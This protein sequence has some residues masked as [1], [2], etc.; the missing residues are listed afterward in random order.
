VLFLAAAAQTCP[1]NIGFENGLFTGWQCFAG[2][3][4]P[5][6]N[7]FLMASTPPVS[8]RHNIIENSATP[9]LD[10]YG[11]F[12]VT[13]PNSSNFSVK[14]GNDSAG[15]EAEGIRYTFTIPANRNDYS[16]IYYYALV[17]Q[18]PDHLPHEQPR[19]TSRVYN[20]TDG[21]YIDCASFEYVSTLGLPGFEESTVMHDVYFKPWAPISINLSGYAGKQIRLEF[22]S[23]DCTIGGHFGYAYIDVN[24]N[25]HAPVTGNYVC[26][27]ADSII[28]KAPPGFNSY[29]WY[30][31]DFTLIG[32]GPA[33]TLKPVPPPGTQFMLEIIPYNGLGCY[34]TLSTVISNPT[35]PINLVVTDSLTACEDKGVNLTLPAVTAGSS[36]GLFLEYFTGVN[37][38]SHVP[39]PRKVIAGGTYYI[40]ATNIEGCQAMQPVEVVLQ[41][42]PLMAITDP[43]PIT[44]PDVVDITDAFITNGSLAGLIFTYWRDEQATSPLSNPQ[45][46][47]QGGTYFIKGTSD[48]GCSNIKPVKVVVL[49][50]A[51]PEVKIPNAFSPNNDGVND[52]FRIEVGGGYNVSRFTVY[53]RWGG[54]VFSA[55]NSQWDGRANGKDLPLGTYYWV[56]ESIEP[57]SG[58][59][60]WHRGSVTLLR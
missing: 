50:P 51:E 36:A 17:F 34:D 55:G 47:K 31:P 22:T 43:P 19:F 21:H 28:L 45:A 59:K 6:E 29:Y 56:M 7:Q 33:L 44:A 37:A 26:E 16:I 53:N 10:H 52:M 20:V 4:R 54:L 30:T 24:Q 3:F 35:I 12:P 39:Y 41:G 13:S 25:C 1:D 57:N 23:Y 9:E 60:V 38:A 2:S 40:Q 5:A 42:K 46:V 58:K 48:A 14:L 18:T 15:A 32:S 49:P 11:K 8:N 27:I